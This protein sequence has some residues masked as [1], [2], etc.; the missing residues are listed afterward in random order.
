MFFRASWLSRCTMVKEE[1]K[2]APGALPLVGLKVLELGH[3]VAGPTAGQILADMGADVIKIESVDGGDQ[4]RSMPGPTGAM[5]HALNRNKRSVALN[6]KEGKGCDIFLRM[7]ASADVVIDNFAYEAVDRLGIGY[8]VVAR[9]NPHV[10]WLSIKG[11]LPGPSETMPML[12]ELAQMAGGL[13][14]MTG[15]EEKPVRA[16]ASI[17]DIGAA[18]YGIIAVLAALR[19]RDTTGHGQFI[20]AGL[21][22]TS[23]YWVAQWM[24]AAQYSGDAS[25]PM[26]TIHQGKRMGFGV[27]RLFNTADNNRV[28]V[29]IISDAHWERFCREFELDSLFADPRFKDRAGRSAN[30]P[31]L[32]EAVALI[33]AGYQREP[34]IS[35]LS[36][37]QVPFAPVRRPDELDSEHHLVSSGQ[38]LSLSLPNGKIAHLPKLPFRSNGYDM[39]LRS[40]AP[41]LGAD[42]RDVL[43]SFGCSETEIADLLAAGAIAIADAADGSLAKHGSLNA[44]R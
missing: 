4:S 44:L 29:G 10:V 35:K 19:Q 1:A 8:E 34:V 18:T 12:D 22:E 43:V 14:F 13:A 33:I 32:N 37:A 9:E 38:L 41:V 6:L 25:V 3:I 23:V 26:S 2:M 27:Y 21:Y 40:S 24:A 5:F 31:E 15:T 11:F 30:L 7:A 16:G 20:V 42:T 28:F 36:N 39:E 17:I